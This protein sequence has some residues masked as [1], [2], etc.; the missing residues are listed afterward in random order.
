M[1]NGN[2]IF[3]FNRLAYRYQIGGAAGNFLINPV[4]GQVDIAVHTAEKGDAH[5]DGTDIEMLLLDHSDGF[6][7]IAYVQHA[8]PPLNAVHGQKDIFVHRVDD[9]A[10]L[11]AQ[12]AHAIR[13][14]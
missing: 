2:A 9:H 14:L 11:F 1:N 6:Q 3:L 10:D 13:K 7:N 4:A 5:G 12:R 8:A